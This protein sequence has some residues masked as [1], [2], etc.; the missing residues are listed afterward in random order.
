MFLSTSD[1]PFARLRKPHAWLAYLMCMS[2]SPLR[3]AAEVCGINLK[4]AFKWRHRFIKPFSKVDKTHLSGIVEVDESLFPL[5]EKG[6]RQLKRQ[7]RKRG[8]KAKKRGPS[9]EHHRIV[10]VARDQQSNTYARPLETASQINIQEAIKNPINPDSILC[11]DGW[12]AYKAV[13]IDLFW[14]N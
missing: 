5:N 3:Q 4:T 14:S 13:A 7:P 11:S 9:H 10:L 8:T 2:Q 6:N 1:S 12:R